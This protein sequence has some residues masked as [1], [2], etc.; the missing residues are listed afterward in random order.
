MKCFVIMPFGSPQKDPDGARKLDQIY[1]EWIRPTVESIKISGNEAQY[2]SCHRADKEVRPGDIITHIIEHLVDS[3][4][5]IADMTGQNPNVFYELGVRHAVRN[6]TI[7]ISESIDDI[8]FDLRTLRAI[9]YKYDPENMLKFR[10][11]LESALNKI[12]S[13]QER[14]DNPV[15]RFLYDRA[16]DVIVKQ[17]VP[18]GYDVVRNILNQ[19]ELLKKEFKLH[20][21]QVQNVM[22]LVT[23]EQQPSRQNISS[24]IKELAIFQGIWV[25]S[26]GGTYCARLVDGE[27]YI[28]YCYRG[29][30]Q[31]TGHYYNCRMV[32]ATMFGRF[33]WFNSSIS[34][35]CFLNIESKNMATGGWWYSHDQYMS[36]TTFH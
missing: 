5:V 2:L 23:A 17:S 30:F 28:P 21:E 34:G 32:G 7:L 4:I 3:F 16:V 25:S 8:P 14:I 10:K 24:A 29:D 11:T 33:K 15:R 31:L 12:V 19:M 36:K 20:A 27:L 22:K 13:D 18:P 26:S 9:Q 6:N 35:Y 1:N